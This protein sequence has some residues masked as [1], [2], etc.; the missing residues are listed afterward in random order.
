MGLFSRLDDANELATGMAHRLGID[1]ESGFQ[2]GPVQAAYQFRDMV[3]RCSTCRHHAECRRLQAH[4]MMLDF[5]PLLP[6]PRTVR[7]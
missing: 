1:L 7:A 3:M 4:S 2:G 6:Q 5:P